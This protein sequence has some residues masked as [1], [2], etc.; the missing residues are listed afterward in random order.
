MINFIVLL[1]V[2][3]IVAQD[4]EVLKGLKDYIIKKEWKNGKFGVP[5]AIVIASIAGLTI[6]IGITDSILQAVGINFNLPDA[7]AYFDLFST[8]L[9]LTRGSGFLIDTLEKFKEVKKET[10]K[11]E[12]E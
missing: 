10:I 11:K 6:N 7:Y 5:L 2:S 4:V 8:C 12:D 1:L 9:L 3:I